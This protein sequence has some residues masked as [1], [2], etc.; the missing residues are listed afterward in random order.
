MEVIFVIISVIFL[1]YFFKFIFSGNNKKSKLEKDLDLIKYMVENSKES[2]LKMFKESSAYD[3]ITERVKQ[4]KN[5]K[6]NK[7]FNE[8]LTIDKLFY[9]FCFHKNVYTSIISPNDN[10]IA[11]IV[12]QL[13][14]NRL[15]ETSFSTSIFTS[16]L[17]KELN[18]NY[19]YQDETLTNIDNGDYFNFI[20]FN[21]PID[22]SG[23]NYL[24]IL[25]IEKDL[26]EVDFIKTLSVARA[27]ILNIIDGLPKRIFV[28][29]ES[30]IGFT[31]REVLANEISNQ[32][33]MFN[34]KIGDED[35]SLI[36]FK[37]I[38]SLE[39]E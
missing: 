30:P 25:E 35:Y 17:N 15:G 12:L 5:E 18:L 1:Y 7:V 38:K 13:V 26:I 8:Q 36:Y 27:F 14:R 2:S 34:E 20:D 4:Y 37:L 11:Q 19:I 31:I 6:T 22:S 10:H 33:L 24:N 32:F 29:N 21:I 16:F 9:R 23:K 3:S 28:L 39:E